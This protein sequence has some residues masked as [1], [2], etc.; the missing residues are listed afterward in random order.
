M[1]I[2][3]DLLFSCCLQDS[4]CMNLVQLQQPEIPV[5]LRKII[6]YGCMHMPLDIYQ[7]SFKIS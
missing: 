3:A 6:I 5:I 2:H 1:E 4:I 7:L